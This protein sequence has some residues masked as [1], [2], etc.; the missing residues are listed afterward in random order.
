MRWIH[1]ELNKVSNISNHY[2]IQGL[3]NRFLG[4]VSQKYKQSVK[5]NNKFEIFKNWKKNSLKNS[6]YIALFPNVMI[7]L[8]LDHF[9]VFWSEPLAINE[10]KEH[11]K[12]YYAGNRSANGYELKELRKEKARFWKEVIL[13][14]TSVI[15]GMQ[16][17][18]A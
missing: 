16:I 1:L 10:T 8:H 17:E 9:Y 7:G 5:G 15:E 3:P 18:R 2:H 11:M 6:E 13:E 12:M 4:Q 14:D